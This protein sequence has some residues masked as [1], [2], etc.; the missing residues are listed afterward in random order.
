MTGRPPKSKTAA[1]W[2][3]VL[4]SYWSWL[5][6]FNGN[7]KKFFIGLVVGLSASVLYIVGQVLYS[8]VLSDW[9]DCWT[10]QILQGGSVEN[11]DLCN[12]VY[13]YGAYTW[14]LW[15]GLIV[16]VGIWVWALV[17]NARRPREYFEKYGR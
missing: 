10:Y 3:A 15:V 14:M 4:F 8:N 1:V 12:A 6:T 2:L 16:S 5:Y 17:D 13:N 7:A 11:A 9:A